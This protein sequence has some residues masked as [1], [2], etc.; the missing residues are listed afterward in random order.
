MLAAYCLLLPYVL[1][2]AAERSQ[3]AL[4]LLAVAA[5]PLAIARADIEHRERTGLVSEHCSVSLQL[6]A[7]AHRISSES[8]LRF[9]A[10]LARYP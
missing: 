8:L 10:T 1:P 2:F 5:K 3:S 9:G 7:A 4:L 6:R